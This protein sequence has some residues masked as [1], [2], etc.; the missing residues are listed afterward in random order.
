MGASPFHA[1]DLC[2]HRF[3]CPCVGQRQYQHT[4]LSAVG[5]SS[6]HRGPFSISGLISTHNC[7]HLPVY[8]CNIIPSNRFIFDS[9]VHNT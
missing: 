3:L 2:F 1:A 8:I 6:F 9:F 7:S 5:Y 4:I